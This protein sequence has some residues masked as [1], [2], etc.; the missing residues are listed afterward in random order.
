MKAIVFSILFLDCSLFVYRNVTDF[1]MLILYPT[2]LLDLLVLSFLFFFFFWLSSYWGF[3][4][5]C[6]CHMQVRILLLLPFRLDDFSSCLLALA[7]TVSN[8]LRRRGKKWASLLCTNLRG[9]TCSSSLLIMMLMV[10]FSYVAST[11]LSSFYNYFAKSFNHAWTLNFINAFS[12][13]AE[14]FI[15]FFSRLCCYCS[16]LGYLS[17]IKPTFHSLGKPYLVIFIHI[18]F[19]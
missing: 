16:E 4:C 6:L 19:I 18:I 3:L 9:K 12:A 13:V 7:R 8:M 1:C 2:I 11:V 14:I 17:N 15:C 10:G 5:I